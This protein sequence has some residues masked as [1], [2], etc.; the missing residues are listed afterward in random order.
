ME[1]QFWKATSMSSGKRNANLAITERQH[2]FFII[3]RTKSNK[4]QTKALI[5]AQRA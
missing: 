5:N 2:P 4:N 3:K 1:L